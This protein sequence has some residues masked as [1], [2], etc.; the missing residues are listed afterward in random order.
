MPNI[1]WKEAQDKENFIN[2]ETRA[3]FIFIRQHLDKGCQGQTHDSPAQEHS[4]L[5]YRKWV[6]MYRKTSIV[7]LT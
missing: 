5:G 1:Y 6:E 7:L 2:A 3:G 4:E